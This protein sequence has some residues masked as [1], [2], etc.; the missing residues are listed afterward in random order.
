MKLKQILT[1]SCLAI[2]GALLLSSTAQATLPY[3]NGDLIMGF[4]TTGASNPAGLNAPTG[5]DYEINLGNAVTFM[6]GSGTINFA[7]IGADLIAIFGAGWNTRADLFWSISGVVQPTV[8]GIPNNTLFATRPETS[9]GTMSIPWPRLSTFAS[10][11]PAN[12]MVSMAGAGFGY[13]AGTN[14]TLNQLESTNTVG[15]LI[16]NAGG[17]SS[18]ASFQPGGANTTGA[19]AF[20]V[21]S[22]GI[23]GNFGA[24]TS[25]TALDLWELTPGS[26]DSFYQGTFHID[27]AGNASYTAGV[28]PEPSSIAILG[29]GTGLLGL[30]RRRQARA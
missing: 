16:Q 10:G 12:K 29:A 28:V 19:T 18:Y 3:S 5:T 26:G 1:T 8:S 30:L 23:E 15:G 24:G 11:A 17:G 20:G 9:I 22:G 21:F 6:S 27:D 13:A 4:R 25:G 7:N 14:A 2:V